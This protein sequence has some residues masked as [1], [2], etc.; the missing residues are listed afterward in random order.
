MPGHRRQYRTNGLASSRGRR[1][2][3]GGA[4]K[5]ELPQDWSDQRIEA[6]LRD[7]AFVVVASVVIDKAGY[8][9]TGW[10]GYV[11]ALWPRTRPNPSR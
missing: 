3:R 1:D 11:G 9:V 10:Q 5:S 6:M 2:V 4:G 8:P 7:G